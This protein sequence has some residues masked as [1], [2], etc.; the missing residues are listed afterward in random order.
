MNELFSNFTW[1]LRNPDSAYEEEILDHWEG[2]LGNVYVSLVLF[3]TMR[4]GDPTF[5]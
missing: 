3:M 1:S 5:D 4:V 2:P